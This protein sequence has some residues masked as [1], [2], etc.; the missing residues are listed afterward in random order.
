MAFRNIL[1]TMSLTVAL[2]F[3]SFVFPAPGGSHALLG[4]VYHRYFLFCVRR[5]QAIYST[6]FI[7]FLAKRFGV[8]FPSQ[9]E[10][11][12]GIEVLFHSSI[13]LSDIIDTCGIC[14]GMILLLVEEYQRTDRDLQASR[15]QSLG[16]SENNAALQAE[17][18]ERHRVEQALRE[19]ESRYRDLIEHSET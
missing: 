12:A 15:L 1:R 6:T 9:L 16:L 11:V 14:L 8:L 19:S 2:V 3:C 13:L 7:D 5:D 4:G 18:L 17:I 10:R